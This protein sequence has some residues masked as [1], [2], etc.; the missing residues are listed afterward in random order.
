MGDRSLC[1]LPITPHSQE[2]I[3]DGVQPFKQHTVNSGTVSAS[4]LFAA[5]SHSLPDPEVGLFGMMP[6]ITVHH[7]QM[8]FGHTAPAP[9]LKCL[10]TAQRRL[11]EEG[12]QTPAD[13]PAP[14]LVP[15]PIAAEPH[16]PSKKTP[17]A[18][19]PLA[20]HYTSQIRCDGEHPSDF[21]VWERTKCQ[22]QGS[23]C[24]GQSAEMVSSGTNIPLSTPKLHPSLPHPLPPHTQMISNTMQV[25]LDSSWHHMATNQSVW[26]PLPSAFARTP[27]AKHGSSGE[28]WIGI[29]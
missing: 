24:Q 7:G 20:L 3:H 8:E 23:R 19:L 26:D 16:P 28:P 29:Q 2:E 17:G 10:T 15:A 25:A 18:P 13:L 27:H 4:K 21:D 11:E 6:P 14:P 12:W 5:S 1:T 9:A 22:W